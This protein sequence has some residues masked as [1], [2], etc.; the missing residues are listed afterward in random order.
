MNSKIKSAPKINLRTAVI[1]LNR[2]WFHFRALK[3]YEKTV[4]KLEGVLRK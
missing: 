3:S 4:L 2:S 1:I